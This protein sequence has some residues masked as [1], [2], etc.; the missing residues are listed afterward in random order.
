LLELAQRLGESSTVYGIDPWAT[1]H[2]RVKKKIAAFNIKNVK[3][4]E[5]DAAH[6]DFEDNT[7][8]LIVSNTGV[9]N[10][11][12]VPKVFREC[13]RVAKP[14]AQ[15]ALTTNPKGHMTEFYRVLK[16]TI[17][18]LGMPHL[19]D[20]VKTHIALRLTG[21]TISNLLH[22]SGFTVSAVLHRTFSMRFASGSAFLNHSLIK[23]G[24][25][26][27]WKDLFPKEELKRVFTALEKNLNAAAREWEEFKVTIP[28]SY[29]EG[30]RP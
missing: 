3:L 9:N 14:G 22:E 28:I 12:D 29:I 2:H 23:V 8:D 19:L 15:I 11:A 26:D 16:Q 7:F 13:F 24:F 4:V 18:Q 10:F 25:L 1:A 5:G 20:K 27:A 21:E 17:H 6:M 30:I